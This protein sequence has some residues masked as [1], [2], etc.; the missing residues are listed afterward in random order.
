M[1][2]AEQAARCCPSGGR[3]GS[4]AMPLSFDRGFRRQIRRPLSA[5]D[6]DQ[7][8]RLLAAICFS[9]EAK[10]SRCGQN[11]TDDEVSMSGK[12]FQQYGGYVLIPL[13]VIAAVV[14]IV[15][16]QSG[17]TG[18]VIFTTVVLAEIYWFGFPRD[19]VEV[20]LDLILPIFSGVIVAAI[21]DDLDQSFAIISGVLITGVAICLAIFMYRVKGDWG[22]L[23]EDWKARASERRASKSD[24]SM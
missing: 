6:V 7:W 13:L 16:G 14:R 2:D 1:E 12:T 18:P 11:W 3:H 9:T 17:L 24:S 5:L 20:S 8:Q 10:E 21:F 23:L 15:F 4:G 19:I 22:R